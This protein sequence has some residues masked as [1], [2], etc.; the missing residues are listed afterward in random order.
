MNALSTLS[1]EPTPPIYHNTTPENLT[2]AK[3]EFV[4]ILGAENVDDNQEACVARSGSQFARALPSHK[5]NLILYPKTTE[6]VSS[7][8]KICWKRC[9]PAIPYSG[10]TGLSGSLAAT[11][12]G[13]CID[14]RDMTKIW[15]LH[16]SDM[17]VTVQP[18]VGWM[19]LNAELASKGL[20]FPPDPA[21]GA[22]IGGMVSLDIID[23]H[24]LTSVS[25]LLW[26]AQVQTPID[27]AP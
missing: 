18:G 5:P 8:L 16:E 14:F 25:R 4:A 6:D 1:L 9:I 11:R 15:N 12:G 7:I 23:N 20:F 26:D 3:E 22:R 2:E 19:E 27:M 13:V 24:S 17:D 10:G 21:P